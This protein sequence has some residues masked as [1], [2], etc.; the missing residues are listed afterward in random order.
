[1]EE[2]IDLRPY[3]L[4]LIRNWKWIIGTSVI[5][6]LIAFVISVFIIPSAYSA[7]AIVA[8]V[9]SKDDIRLDSGI[10]EIPGN[11]P[12]SA[13]PDLALSDEVL[14]DLLDSLSLNESL[15]IS[16]LRENLDAKSGRD[17]SIIILTA[18]FENPEMA[19][20]IANVWGKSFVSWAN[21]LYA[22]QSEEQVLF[23]EEQL[24]EAEQNLLLAETKLEEFQ[25]INHTQI[26]SNSLEVQQQR[27]M[28]FLLQQSN[29]DQLLTHARVLR[30]Q[31]LNISPTDD[32]SYADQL[33]FLQLQLQSFNNEP[34]LPLILQIDSQ[35]PLITEDR[36]KHIE[37]IDG[38]IHTLEELAVQVDVNLTEIEPQI[39]TLQQDKQISLTELNRLN[40]DLNITQSTYTAL[41]YQ[42]TEERIASQNNNI[43]FQLASRAV[44]PAEPVTRHLFIS[45]A[46]AIVGAMLSLFI[47]LIV[48]WWGKGNNNNLSNSKHIQE[49]PT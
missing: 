16:K 18:T 19:V 27:H 4:T 49:T 28:D 21:R 32:V 23:F 15:S 17:N 1:M 30:E 12:F 8:V 6:T 48:E 39:L 36:N 34:A 24:A 45:V 25:V 22:G 31:M 5:V 9:A 37:I 11:Q 43:G 41:A 40:Q 35:E 26:I 33:T 14:N 44:V 20:Q 3:I 2:E 42:V 10:I 13:F 47:I 7:T 46:A 29:I 38:L